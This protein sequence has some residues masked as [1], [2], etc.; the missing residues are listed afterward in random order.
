MLDEI[1][2][3]KQQTQSRTSLLLVNERGVPLSY[4]TFRSRFDKA[5]AAAGVPKGEF[6]LRDLRATAATLVDE[7]HG[8]RAAQSLGHTTEQ[9]T[10]IYVRHKVG[11]KVAPVR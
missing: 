5:R 8:I 7:E 1:A 9:T 2:E 3:F 10:A 11:K 4:D 6:Q